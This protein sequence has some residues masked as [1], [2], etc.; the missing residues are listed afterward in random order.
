MKMP[1]SQP[2]V[3]YLARGKLHVRFPNKEPQE[4]ESPFARQYVERQLRDL[5]IDGWKGRSGVWAGMGMAPPSMAQWQTA[6]GSP[7]QPPR[8]ISLARGQQPRELWYAVSMGNVGGLFRYDL[9]Q[10]QELRL[11]HKEAFLPRDL[12]VHPQTANLALAIERDPGT[13][14]LATSKHEGR[15]LTTVASG[16]T[17]DASPSWTPG[18]EEKLVFQSARVGRSREGYPMGLGPF[19]IRSVD[20]AT[21]EL[22][23]LLESKEHDYL[24]PRLRSDGSLYY[25]RRPY[26][27]VGA[28]PIRLKDF[29]LD[30]LLFPYR[31]LRALFYTANFF[32]LMFSGKPLATTAGAP[33]SPED[34]VAMSLWGQMI[35]TKKALADRSRSDDAAVVPKNYEL[36]CRDAAGS[37]RVVATNVLSYDITGD[38][39]V[40]YTNGFGLFHL[41]PDGRKTRLCDDDLID[42]VV[43]VEV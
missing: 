34:A 40:V 2:L 27:K 21:G 8:I 20:L 24:A 12:A 15:F 14:R 18:E 31:L 4:I 7:I 5:E 17:V 30:V 43:A 10:D 36:V 16:D 11:M 25:I 23:T 1:S 32:S 3:A 13:Y 9:N 28:K 19:A 38:G 37:E 22:N 39:D 29:L 35:D 6:G 33:R 26:E 42:Q 41:T